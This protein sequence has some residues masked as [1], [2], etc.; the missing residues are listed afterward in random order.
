MKRERIIQKAMFYINSIDLVLF[1]SICPGSGS[2]PAHLYVRLNRNN[3]NKGGRPQFCCSKR[4]DRNGG[5]GGIL[6]Y[7]AVHIDGTTAAAAAA[8]LLRRGG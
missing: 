5:K 1:F 6:H 8:A 4:S 7:V 3:Q 2:P